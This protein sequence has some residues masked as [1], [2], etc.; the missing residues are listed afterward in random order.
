MWCVQGR[1]WKLISIPCAQPQ[2]GWS[3]ASLHAAATDLGYSPA[4][5]GLVANGA[6]GLVQV[7]WRSSNS[8]YQLTPRLQHFVDTCNSAL[9]LE[10]QQM[11]PQLES[12]RVRDRVVTGV[13]VRL[14]MVAPYIATWPQALSLQAHPAALPTSLKQLAAAVDEIWRA[15]GDTSTDSNWYTK[16]ALLAGVYTATELYMLT[17]GSPGFADTW[18]QLARRV[19][20]VVAVG[21]QLRQAGQLEGLVEMLRNLRPR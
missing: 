14:E 15:A 18:E 21:K 7:R 9:V 12:M 8:Q 20:D 11:A 17:D 5:A 3:A 16:R 10:L 19:D 13:R 2:H 4:A 6:T 1:P